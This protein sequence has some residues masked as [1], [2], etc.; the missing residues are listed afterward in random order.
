MKNV[1]LKWF[2]KLALFALLFIL[3][4]VSFGV[5]MKSLDRRAALL[6]PE[7]DKTRF[8]LH[9]VNADVLVIGASEVEFQNVEDTGIVYRSSS[10]ADGESLVFVGSLQPDGPGGCFLMDHFIQV[11][12]DLLDVSDVK[13][14]ETMDDIVNIHMG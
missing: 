3:F 10:E 14:T 6:C 11:T 13:N 2:S 1:Y 5:V 8:L 4:D 9:D 7:S 12:V